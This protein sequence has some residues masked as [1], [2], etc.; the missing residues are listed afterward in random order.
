MVIHETTHHS[1]VRNE[2]TKP[3]FSEYCLF[4]G[5]PSLGMTEIVFSKAELLLRSWS[6]YREDKNKK[7]GPD[8]HGYDTG[9]L[10]Q[11]GSREQSLTII[12]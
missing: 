12:Q 8:P 4:Q 5:V 9:C 10:N 11:R 6:L 2:I 7:M 1:H 3:P